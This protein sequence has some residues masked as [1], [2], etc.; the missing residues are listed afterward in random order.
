MDLGSIMLSEIGKE[1]TVWFH[2]HVESK[3]NKCANL[4]NTETVIEIENK[5]V[6]AREEA[7]GRRKE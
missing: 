1:Y 2:L 7:G 4:N 5:Q 3:Q 6:V